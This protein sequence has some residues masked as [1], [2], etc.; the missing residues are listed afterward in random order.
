V[1]HYRDVRTKCSD[2]GCINGDATTFERPTGPFVLLLANPFRGV[3]LARVVE[4]L[5][6][7]AR[8]LTRDIYVVYYHPGR[9]HDDWD[10]ADFLTCVSRRPKY[11]VYRRR[12]PD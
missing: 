8:E 12:E 11:S 4:R 9:R 2:I 6:D 7:T 1:R 3:V 10:R 5:R